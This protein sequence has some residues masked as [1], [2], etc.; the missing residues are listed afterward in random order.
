M[1]PNDGLPA[2]VCAE[3]ENNTLS[4]QNIRHCLPCTYTCD[5][6]TNR[7][8]FECASTLG[9]TATAKCKGW[10]ESNE[11]CYVTREV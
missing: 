5:S 3:T 1:T 8:V 9:G 2:V 6:S 11:H 7:R 10:T 4:L